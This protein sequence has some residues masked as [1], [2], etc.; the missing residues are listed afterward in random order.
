MGSFETDGVFG[1]KVRAFLPRLFYLSNDDIQVVFRVLIVLLGGQWRRLGDMDCAGGDSARGALRGFGVGGVWLDA[2]MGCRSRVEAPGEL[3][4][5]RPEVFGLG[6][7]MNGSWSVE[8]GNAE[9]WADGGE[10]SC[11]RAGEHVGEGH[12]IMDE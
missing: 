6:S 4:G 2:F 5:Q 8:A 11:G 7:E 1:L 3:L 10:E 12:L 9:G